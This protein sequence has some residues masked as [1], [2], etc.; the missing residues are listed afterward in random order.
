MSEDEKYDVQVKIRCTRSE[1]M[2]LKDMAKDA[3]MTQS[4]LMRRWINGK[5]VV[6]M[7]DFR[8]IAELRRQ[9]GLM[10]H[11]AFEGMSQRKMEKSLGEVLYG[12]GQQILNQ[13]KEIRDDLEK[14]KWKD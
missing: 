2:K 3:G 9:G 12:M 6:A 14:G 13:A 1:F 8:L 10:K 5:R 4:E 11:L 7:T